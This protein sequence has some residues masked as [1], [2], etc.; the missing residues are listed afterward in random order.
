M[1][2]VFQGIILQAG[3]VEKTFYFSNVKIESRD[4][5][6]TVNFDNT[7]L[8][9]IPGEPLL[10]W[11]EVVLM[12]PPGESA[13]S[14]EVINEQ[15]TTMPGTFILPP[16]QPVS[17][18][19][20]EKP[21]EF[22]RN[23]KVYQQQESY[24]ARET[25]HLLTQYYNGYAFALCTFTPVRYNP[26]AG[27]LS[28]FGKV[29]VKIKT[30]ADARSLA[31]QNILPTAGNVL[32]RVKAFAMNPEMMS[33]Y[34]Q[35]DAPALGYDYLII[36]PVIF[37]NEFQ[38]VIS[39]YAGK[40]MIAKV[41]TTDSISSV[42]TGYDLPE[43][44]RNFIINQ[45]INNQVQYVLL[46]GNPPLVPFRRLHCSVNSDMVYV[47]S[48]PSDLYYSGLDGNFDA[49]GNH[50]YGEILPDNPDLLPDIAVARFT[51][52]DT[53]ELHRMI[54]KTVSYQTNPVL[55]EFSRP[56]MAGEYLYAS[57][58]TYGGSYMDLLIDDHADSGYF[59]HG[60]PS[61][62]NDIKK[63]YDIPG[64]SWSSANL[65]A[66]INQ[67]NSF[68]HHLGHANSGYMMRLYTSNITNANFSQV[69]GI[70]HNYQLLYTQG[71][72]DGAFDVSGGCI[73]AKAVT[74]ANFLVAGIFNSR[75]GW[76]DQGTS[77]GPSQ[78]LER[79]FVS[80]IYTTT[81]PEKH[82]GTV[83]MISKVKTAPWISLPGEFEPGA[84]LW[85]H[86][87]CNVFGD[88]ALEIRTEEPTSFTTITWTGTLDSDWNKAGNWDLARVPTTLNDVMIPEAPHSPV[89]TTINATFCHNVTI[90]S[91]GNLTINPGKSMVAYG[92]VK[93]APA[94]T[95][96]TLGES[97]GGGN[98]FWLDGTA[99][100]GLIAAT[101]DL[102]PAGGT[103]WFNNTFEITGANED[104]AFTGVN[105][106][107]K[108]VALQGSGS[109]AARLC[110]D[111]SKT[112]GTVTYNDW[113]L[114]SKYE[115]NQ[116]YLHRS[117]LAPFNYS[118]GIYWSSTEG[119]TDPLKES[120]DQ[121]FMNGSDSGIQEESQKDWPDQ[122]RCIRKF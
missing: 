37:K 122:V 53:A 78:H 7:I 118:Y 39:M 47:D 84:Q 96:H 57:P 36:S 24:P 93:L 6:Q 13:E 54:H 64:W 73:A 87:D 117:L 29:T 102:G 100:H 21:G 17:H 97:Y 8:S 112:I 106:T 38:P 76:F 75:Y 79:E 26:A 43:K 46:A 59:T 109:Y 44:I 15:E 32:S 28:Y 103:K 113:Y 105:N 77:D 60:I 52:N 115:L 86:Y 62:S 119:I 94:T 61:N 68:I 20:S 16:K 55:G 18:T 101:V 4:A 90:Q 111:Y 33:S 3:I 89:I 1:L 34:P 25:G 9:G 110:K 22:V 72:D 40:G 2:A 69:N 80:A 12:L 42:M 98:I 120:F 121:V 92:W 58:V 85:C 108:I 41:V 31:A 99:T 30:R 81:L 88:P 63:L 10:P 14:I 114:P 5:F 23:E 82:L 91:G 49:N 35:K 51:V 107:D 45:R 19:F 50:K 70:T 95:M 27:K 67:G 56:L 83:Q 11:H 65:L 74:I 48:I 71:C 66:A 104:G 116:M